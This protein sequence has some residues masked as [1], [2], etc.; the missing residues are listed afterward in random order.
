[1]QALSFIASAL[2]IS[3]GDEIVFRYKF[4]FQ[5]LIKTNNPG[6]NTEA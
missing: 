6:S 3:M 4:N 1:M 2:S 5:M